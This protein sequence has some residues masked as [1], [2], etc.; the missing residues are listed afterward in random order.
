MKIGFFAIVLMFFAVIQTA[1]LYAADPAELRTEADRYYQEHN[2]KKAYRIYFKLAKTGD[3]HA[4]D[5]VAQMYARGEGKPEDITEAYAWSILAE[6]GGEKF[7]TESS[8]SLLERTI[9][10]KKAQKKADK[11]KAKYGKQALNDKT[12]KRAEMEA[13]RRSGESMGSNLSR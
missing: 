5:R 11:L 8:K 3:Y 7:L 13:A 6:E 2:F 1:V 4:Q 9:D 12:R 10:K